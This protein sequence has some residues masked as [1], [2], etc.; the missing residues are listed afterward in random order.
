MNTDSEVKH[1]FMF[2]APD[3]T[4][5]DIKRI[6]DSEPSH[7]DVE[8]IRDKAERTWPQWKIN[9]YNKYIAISAHARK[10]NDRSNE[11]D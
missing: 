1:A 8:I 6:E 9:L 2:E 5:L 7:I 4:Y 10:L 11:D 3:G